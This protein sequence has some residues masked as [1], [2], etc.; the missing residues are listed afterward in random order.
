MPLRCGGA[1]RVDGHAPVG[2]G[3]LLLG[4]SRAGLIDAGKY[5]NDPEVGDLLNT[6][7]VIVDVVAGPTSNF[8]A[9]QLAV[10]FLKSGSES[11]LFTRVCAEVQRLERGYPLRSVL[12]EGSV[13]P[14]APDCSTSCRDHLQVLPV[15]DCNPLI[16]EMVSLDER[17]HLLHHR[18]ERRQQ[19]SEGHHLACGCSVLCRGDHLVSSSLLV[20]SVDRVVAMLCCCGIYTSS[21][22]SAC[23][24][25]A[26]AFP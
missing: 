16:G 20:H 14:P 13:S 1:G 15:P 9:R 10:V 25:K 26:T 7:L 11:M 3:W 22:L 6:L 18:K 5:R 24:F 23:D 12:G 4:R 21:P 17:Y 2:A 8:P 19:E